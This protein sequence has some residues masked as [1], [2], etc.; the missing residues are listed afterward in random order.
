MSEI[1]RYEFNRR[2]GCV[3]NYSNGD[4]VKH[5]DHLA[6]IEAVKKEAVVEWLKSIKAKCGS[7]CDPNCKFSPLCYM[8]AMYWEDED[9]QKAAEV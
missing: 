3:F 5:S 7:S 6:A 1:K 2:T 4:Y 8:R 9:I